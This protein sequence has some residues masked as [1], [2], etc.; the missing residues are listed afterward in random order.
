[1]KPTAN[2]G[3]GD[4]VDRL[5]KRGLLLTSAESGQTCGANSWILN[6]R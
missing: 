2:Q 1:M 3:P 6:R 5:V 4:E